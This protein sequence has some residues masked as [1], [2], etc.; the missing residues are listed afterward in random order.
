MSTVVAV[1]R[2]TPAAVSNSAEDATRE[3]RASSS[4]C[5][6]RDAGREGDQPGLGPTDRVRPG[7][8]CPSRGDRAL[9][10]AVRPRRAHGRRRRRGNC[11]R[12]GPASVPRRGRRRL[13]PAPGL[14][15]PAPGPALIASWFGQ[16]PG[17]RRGGRQGA[18]S[19]RPC[20]HRSLAGRT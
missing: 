12:G 13:L 15:V 14:A 11:A 16:P 6:R 8:R 7:R 2:T 4:L 3:V 20:P 10:L 9:A 17:T 5:R 19:P 18:R 1:V